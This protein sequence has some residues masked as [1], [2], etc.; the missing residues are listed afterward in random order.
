MSE[1]VHPTT[2]PESPHPHTLEN[3]QSEAE[4]A[5]PSLENL[6]TSIKASWELS[7]LLIPGAKVLAGLSMFVT[8]AMP[9]MASAQAVHEQPQGPPQAIRQDASQRLQEIQ[10]PTATRSQVTTTELGGGFGGGGGQPLGPS[11]DDLEQVK[12]GK[13]LT[14]TMYAKIQQERFNNK[15]PPLPPN[16]LEN[17]KRIDFM[18]KYPIFS[19]GA[20]AAIE[21]SCHTR[22]FTM[23]GENGLT[24]GAVFEGKDGK[25]YVVTKIIPRNEDNPRDRVIL[26]PVDLPINNN[27]ARDETTTMNI[28]SSALRDLNYLPEIS[29]Q[30]GDMIRLIQG[31]QNLRLNSPTH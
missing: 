26:V 17:R 15:Y 1:F 27:D 29:A 5:S 13:Y 20:V 11:P 25:L 19:L 12:P 18:V 22:D 14:D 30:Y 16:T 24:C 3:Q 10:E 8:T 2:T 31:G 21:A 23:R 6:H 4:G 28:S 9:A 7:R